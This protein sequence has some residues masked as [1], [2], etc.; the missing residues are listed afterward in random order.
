M[1]KTL[2]LIICLLITILV[3]LNL[4]KITDYIRWK[5]ISENHPWAPANTLPSQSHRCGL[6]CRTGSAK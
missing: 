4:D 2:E 3:V 1:K 6:L 5:L